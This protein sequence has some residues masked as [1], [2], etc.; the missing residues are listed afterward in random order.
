MSDAVIRELEP[1]GFDPSEPNSSLGEWYLRF[2]EKRLSELTDDDLGIAIRQRVFLQ[3]IVPRAVARLIEL[4]YAGHQFDGE[5][6]VAIA[7]L[8][9]EEFQ[10]NKQTRADLRNSLLRESEEFDSLDLPEYEVFLTR[11]SESLD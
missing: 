3:Q 9:E 5:L 7:A 1:L 6:L 10:V 2:R 4:P 11:L 8:S